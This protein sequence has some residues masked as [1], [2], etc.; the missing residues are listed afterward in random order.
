MNKQVAREKRQLQP[1]L[2]VFPAAH[3]FVLRQEMLD[4]APRKLLRNAL[5]MFRT[6][7]H[8]IPACLRRGNQALLTASDWPLDVQ[9]A[10]LKCDELNFG[11]AHA[12][13]YTTP[14]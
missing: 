13:L 4:A 7:V 1:H 8:G 3:G 2:A 10:G 5:L 11:C 6:G 9:G 12:S 14:P